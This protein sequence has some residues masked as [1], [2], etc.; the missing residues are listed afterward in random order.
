MNLATLDTFN[1]HDLRRGVIDQCSTDLD[2][3]SLPV[4]SLTT[5]ITT[6]TTAAAAATI[7][8]RFETLNDDQSH[9]FVLREC[10]GDIDDADGEE[11]GFLGEGE[12]CTGIDVDGPVGC[13]T[14]EEPEIAVSDGVGGGDEAGVEGSLQGCWFG[15]DVETCRRFAQ[16]KDAFVCREDRVFGGC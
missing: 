5:T 2:A 9:S 8:G 10:P 11:A 1:P 7:E 14:V 12:M 16:S 15:E 6:T 4:S 13:E 3:F